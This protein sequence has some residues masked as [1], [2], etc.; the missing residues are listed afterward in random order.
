MLLLGIEKKILYIWTRHEEK[1]SGF[2]LITMAINNF[3]RFNAKHTV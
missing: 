3:S 2:L 1:S